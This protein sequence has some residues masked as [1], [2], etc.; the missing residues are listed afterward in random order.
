MKIANE[1]V[2]GGL[3]CSEVLERL[4]DY[5]DGD[6]PAAERGKVEEHLRGCEGCTRFGGEFRATVTALRARLVGVAAPPQVRERLREALRREP[7]PR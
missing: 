1:K 4:S 6:L 7:G 2:V 5:L 3:S